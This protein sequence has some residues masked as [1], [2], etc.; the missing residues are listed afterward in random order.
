MQ[1]RNLPKIQPRAR[2]VDI[3]AEG[4]SVAVARP[5]LIVIP[6][7]LDG[8]LW[9]GLKI[10][11]AAL[12]HSLINLVNDQDIEDSKDLIDSLSDLATSNMVQLGSTFTPSMLS[13]VPRDKIYEITEQ[14]VWRPDSSGLVLLVGIGLFLVGAVISMAYSVPIADAI[15]GR[16]R[17]F[18]EKLRAIGRASYRMF[19]LIAMVIGGVI[20]VAIPIGIVAAISAVAGVALLSLFTVAIVVALIFV[21]FYGTFVFDAMVVADVG[22]ITAIRYSAGVVHRNRRSTIGFV[23]ASLLLGT[24]IPQIAEGVLGSAPGLIIAVGIHA[25]VATGVSAASLLFFVDRMRFWQPDLI[26]LPN[27]APAF[28]LV[29]QGETRS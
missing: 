10:E 24:G 15:L 11:P 21:F 2:I 27:N 1:Q 23:L 7:L 28:D 6:I 17:S 9:I 29:R 25:L 18:S 4:L 20:A 12:M 22:P 26:S 8:L 3:I 13:G 5:W 16:K 19:L 14:T